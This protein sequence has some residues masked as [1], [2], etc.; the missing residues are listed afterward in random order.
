MQVTFYGVRGSAPAP[1]P[2]TVRYG[3]NTVCVEV[4]LSDGSLL[5]L[6]A[7]TGLRMLGKAR[8]PS[9]QSLTP[10][11]PG[12]FNPRAPVHLL[13]THV[14]YDHICGLPFL[15]P[16]WDPQGDLVLHALSPCAEDRLTRARL[17]DGEHFPVRVQDLP[18][19]IS[20][21]PYEGEVKRIGPATVRR[22]ALN[23]PGEC[24]GFRIEDAGRSLC[25]LTDN[26]LSPRGATRVTPRTTIDELARFS[27]GTDLLIHDAQYTEDELRTRHGYGHSSVS[28]VLRLGQAAG[29]RRL[30]LFHHDPDHDDDALD[31]IG[32]EARAWA[33][34][35]A[36]DTQ[37]LMAAEGLRLDLR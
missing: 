17:F 20:A 32:Q 16:I 33:A 1:G 22:V 36:P 31:R 30:A 14:H 29:A 18:A 11:P 37:L 10:S 6:D 27:A 26:E 25:Y 4:L 28:E 24:D 5:I 13:I 23:H 3:G 7:G 21:P 35:H 8:F 15:P 2:T 19:R 34:A 12:D 9:P